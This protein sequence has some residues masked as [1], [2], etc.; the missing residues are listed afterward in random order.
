MACIV[1]LS[2]VAGGLHGTREATINHWDT[3]H[4]RF[5]NAKPMFWNP[6][7]SWTR[8]QY[9]GYKFDFYH[10]GESLKQWCLIGIGFLVA[11]GIQPMW[12]YILSLA[13]SFVTYSLGNYLV[14]MVVK[15][16]K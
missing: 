7:V 4:A 6:K 16:K 15:N 11:F 12:K 10:M 9:L 1:L 14:E 3:F 2:I 5:P 13:T 8:P